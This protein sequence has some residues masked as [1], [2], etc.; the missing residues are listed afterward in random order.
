MSGVMQENRSS[1]LWLRLLGC[2]AILASL[3]LVSVTLIRHTGSA[4]NFLKHGACLL[5]GLCFL[6]C[7][8][9]RK[10]LGLVTGIGG[11]LCLIAADILRWNNGSQSLAGALVP[12]V[13]PTAFL[14]FFFWRA[15][16]K[17]SNAD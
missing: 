12:W 13:L 17:N 3:Y 4:V 5:V 9:R 8:L 16:R 2:L 10:W 11:L 15:S 6:S 14:I 7:G 1:Y